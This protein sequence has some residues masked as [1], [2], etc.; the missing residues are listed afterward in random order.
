MAQTQQERLMELIPLVNRYW[1]EYHIQK[2]PT[3]SDGEYDELFNELI[4][5]Q[6][7]LGIYMANSPT[8]R[9]GKKPEVIEEKVMVSAPVLPVEQVHDILRLV[10]FQKNKQLMLMLQP[11]GVKVKLVYEKH[12][13]V[14]A[15]TCGEDGIGRH[16]LHLV[17]GISGIPIL[18]T[19]EERLVISGKV[20]IPPSV[21]GERKDTLCNGTE[22]RDL[23]ERPLVADALY[24][25]DTNQCRRLGLCFQVNRVLEGIEERPYH[26][27]RFAKLSDYGFDGCKHFVANRLLTRNDMERGIRQ[28]QEYAKTHDIPYGGILVSYNDAAYGASCDCSVLHYRQKEPLVDPQMLVKYLR[29]TGKDAMDI[30][31]LSEEI[32]EK[33][34]H[35]GLIQSYADIYRLD[36]H[37]DKITA[38]EGFNG[39]LWQ[40]LWAAIQ[41]SRNTTLD[42][43]L[44][45][46]G[47]P[48]IGKNESRTLAEYFWGD[49][50]AFA[51]A[52]DNL[53]D[54][55]KM[56]GFE[57]A[58]HDSIYRWFWNE[59]N[60]CMWFELR[61]EFMIRHMEVGPRESKRKAA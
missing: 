3:V 44:F 6:T 11:E 14:Q 48:M 23:D 1:E 32:L 35:K 8:M 9:G 31:E 7:E 49:P 59:E 28:L 29:F 33:L 42:R 53:F 4:G 57:D 27:G 40:K 15:V 51:D 55:R 10:S 19:R 37:R 17:Y 21:V 43:F 46:M 47:I 52:V 36:A 60:Y 39:A 5:L 2:A 34:I 45:A 50:D 41:R 58:Q 26:S 16:I 54:F 56:K 25:M 22:K 24:R 13:L 38:M 61:E 20:F 18:V 30:P 12:Q